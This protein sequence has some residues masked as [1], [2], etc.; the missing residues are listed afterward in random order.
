VQLA[1]QSAAQS[2]A[3]RVKTE[4]NDLLFIGNDAL[5]QFDLLGLTLLES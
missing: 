2:L 5:V 3:I 4:P 1:P